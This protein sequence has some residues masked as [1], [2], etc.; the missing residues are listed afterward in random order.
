MLSRSIRR[1]WSHQMQPTCPM[2]SVRA[3]QTQDGGEC[4]V[5]DFATGTCKL[6]E[7][8]CMCLFEEHMSYILSMLLATPDPTHLPL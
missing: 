2:G 5:C 3:L 6:A 4:I 8:F 7:L 1:H